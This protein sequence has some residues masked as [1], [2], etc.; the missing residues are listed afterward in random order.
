[1]ELLLNLLWVIIA[2]AG[3]LLAPRRS[4]RTLLA[5]IL[6]LAV[7][8]PI[9]SASDDVNAIPTFYDALAT[10]VVSIV[11]SIAFVAIAR[12]S[13]IPVAVS[14]VHIAT[15]SDPRSPPAR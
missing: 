7:L 9:I 12:L 1:M 8:F 15:P 3:F 13:A 14:T 5:L 4:G 10:L 11:L 2:T 6:A